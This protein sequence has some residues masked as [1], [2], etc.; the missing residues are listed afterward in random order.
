MSIETKTSQMYAYLM[1]KLGNDFDGHSIINW[2][3]QMFNL[4]PFNLV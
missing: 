1:E 3:E 4:K 2:A